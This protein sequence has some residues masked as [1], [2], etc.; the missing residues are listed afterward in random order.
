MKR[1]LRRLDHLTKEDIVT[2]KGK[3]ACEISA[4]DEILLSELVFSG[5][6]EHLQKGELCAILSMFV[7][8]ESGGAKGDQGVVKDEKLGSICMEVLDMARKIVKI[9]QESKIEVDEQ[10]YVGSFKMSLVDVTLAWCRG[11]SFAEICKMSPLF[12]GS[13]IRGLRRLDELLKQL[14]NAA[15]SIGNL[16]LEEK[17]EEASKTLKRGIVFAASL[18]VGF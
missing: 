10:N 6:F 14:G 5:S 4:A 7:C 9:Y 11:A 13:I 12:E 15:K 8:D 3:V 1:V 17:F 2:H 16:Q 18:Y